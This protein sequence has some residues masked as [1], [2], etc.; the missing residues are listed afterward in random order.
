MSKI[1][2]YIEFEKGN[3]PLILSVP[4]GGLLKCDSIP[5][6]TEGVLG[7]DKGTIEL[8]KD[9]M[10]QINLNFETKVMGV[11]TPFYISSKVRRS[12]VDLNRRMHEAYNQKSFLAR[13]IYGFYHNKI[14]EW[15][16]E[17]LENY[18]RSLLI[19]IHGFEKESRPP[20]FRD[21]D[22]ILG[23]NNL[24]SLFSK[25]IK[26]RD[27]NKNIRGKIIQELLQLGMSIAPGHP[28]R[29]EYVLTG[30]HTTTNYGASR[31]SKSQTIQIEFSDRIRLYDEK[32]KETVIKSLAHILFEDEH[33]PNY[34]MR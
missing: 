9:L 2:E 33:E 16:F 22:I 3:I 21:V 27:W 23:T 8:A 31:I 30:G 28:R 15:I 12:K 5:H 26:K 1:K 19:D 6:R 11:K 7:I 17:N 20:G 4:H 13:E 18:N 34:L 24:E 25:P 14:K 32:L 29:K 10:K